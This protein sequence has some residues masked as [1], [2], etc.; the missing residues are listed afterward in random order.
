LIISLSA[1]ILIAVNL[2]QYWQVGW[3]K[4]ALVSVILVPLLVLGCGMLSRR[5]KCS[6]SESE[7]EKSNS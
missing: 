7:N 1:V 3:S 4:F 2:H 5:E 6:I